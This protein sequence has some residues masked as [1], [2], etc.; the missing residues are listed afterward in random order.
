MV[1]VGGK[2]IYCFIENVANGTIDP[3][4][5]FSVTASH[6]N[7]V[8]RNSFTP[9]SKKVYYPMNGSCRACRGRLGDV[10]LD[11]VWADAA[12]SAGFKGNTDP[13]PGTT[14]TYDTIWDVVEDFNLSTKAQNTFSQPGY[15]SGGLIMTFGK[16]AHRGVDICCP[17]IEW[18]SIK[19]PDK[20]DTPD[21][22][23]YTFVDAPGVLPRIFTS[24]GTKR[25]SYHTQLWFVR[26][27]SMEYMV[28][29][30]NCSVDISWRSFPTNRANVTI[31]VEW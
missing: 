5:L 12:L 26:N 13:I 23:G 31:N 7:I 2:N 24:S 17:K 6:P 3:I 8:V 27:T 11:Y 10:T 30:L 19:L 14:L 25:N 9:P 21:N 18:R 4:G 28:F 15:I 29:S 20:D 22:I 16:R 1:E